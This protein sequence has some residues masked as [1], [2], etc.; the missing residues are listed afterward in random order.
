MQLAFISTHCFNVLTFL[1]LEIS[2]PPIWNGVPMDLESGSQL[3]ELPLIIQKRLP[4]YGTT[5][6]NAGDELTLTR[7]MMA[8][9][10]RD[11]NNN[12]KEGLD[13]WYSFDKISDKQFYVRIIEKGIHNIEGNAE[14][15]L[16]TDVQYGIIFE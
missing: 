6:V 16:F 11:K 12:N 9:L 15:Y 3:P 13:G 14:V 10:I 7:I 5:E 2:D 8:F 4:M 1:C